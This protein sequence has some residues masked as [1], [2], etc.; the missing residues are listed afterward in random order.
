MLLLQVLS[1][2]F[3]F[4]FIDFSYVFYFIFILFFFKIVHL[5]FIYIG[6]CFETTLD[7]APN[8]EV[9]FPLC[10]NGVEKE[11]TN[12]NRKEFVAL[13][14]D[15]KLKFR[16]RKVIIYFI[17]IFFFILF[18]FVYFFCFFFCFS[19]VCFSK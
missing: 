17:F 14:V 15:Y 3:F 5:L 19:F 7:I 6:L 12:K 18:F 11:V 16:T 2:F 13:M 1:L 10:A 8:V 4:Y 9:P